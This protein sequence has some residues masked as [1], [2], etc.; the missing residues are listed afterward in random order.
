M[1]NTLWRVAAS[2]AVDTKAKLFVIARI[3]LPEE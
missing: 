2:M 1:R 3:C